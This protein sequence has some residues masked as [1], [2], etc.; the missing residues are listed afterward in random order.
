MRLPID[1]LVLATG[2]LA[3]PRSCYFSFCNHLSIHILRELKFPAISNSGRAG[4][5]NQRRPSTDALVRLGKVGQGQV[6]E[7]GDQ[8]SRNLGT[9]RLQ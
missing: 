4:C 1:C 5:S 3:S 9:W 8:H 6:T 7:A 2:V